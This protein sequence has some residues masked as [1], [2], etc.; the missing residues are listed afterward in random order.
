M[1]LIVERPTITVQE[2]SD[3]FRRR[4][5]LELYHPLLER[6]ARQA[7]DLILSESATLGTIR[8][9]LLSFERRNPGSKTDFEA[10][11]GEF[12]RAFLCPAMCVQAFRHS[13]RVFGLDG[14]HIKAKYGGV[15]LVATVLDG[16]GNVFPGAIGIAES[17]NEDTWSWFIVLLRS[18]L[19]FEEGNVL[20]VIS[21]REKGIKKTVKFLPSAHHSY[22]VFH[23]QKNV[24]TKFKT[25]LNGLLFKAAKAANEADFLAAIDEMKSIHG[26][27]AEYVERIKPHKWARSHFPVRR[28]GHV[29]SNMAES[30]NH[31]LDDARH[32][33]PVRL[34]NSYVRKLNVLFEKRRERYA[35]MEETDLPRNVAKTLNKAIE[36]GLRLKIFPHTR[37]IAEVERLNDPN[38]TRVVDLATLTC[39]CG[40]FNEFGV[41]CRHMCK[42]ASFIGVH[43]KTM[44]VPELLVSALKET[45][46][47]FTVPVDL[48][49]LEEDGTKAPT[50]TKRRGRP[51][52]KRIKSSAEKMTKRTVVCGVCGKRGH[53]AR[54]C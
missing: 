44:V 42:A 47:R 35:S 46:N 23:I 33:D 51:R 49:G 4:F 26:T 12:R 6:C 43:P 10:D 13:T 11:N 9:F 41:P 54:T 39:S 8:S 2:L 19:H 1:T 22:C 53:N 16:N 28:F 31:W 29:T 45:Y 37:M 36:E 50:K 20:V 40:F 30:M 52:E 38:V 3:C 24:K 21:D 18:A 14:C 5:G 7:R 48:N 27:A 25:C 15:V 17:E 34:F 32:Q